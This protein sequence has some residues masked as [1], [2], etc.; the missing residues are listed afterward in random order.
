[1][2]RQAYQELQ[3]D[4]ENSVGAPPTHIP[5]IST[6]YPFQ[7]QQ[8]TQYRPYSPIMTRPVRESGITI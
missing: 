7:I 6:A 4:Y 2:Q 3:R 5:P 8:Q 1:M